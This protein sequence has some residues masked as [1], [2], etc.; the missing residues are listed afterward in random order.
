MSG[1]DAVAPGRARDKHTRSGVAAEIDPGRS[2]T[3]VFPFSL[4]QMGKAL[5]G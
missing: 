2:N 3:I 1:I 4:E 5:R